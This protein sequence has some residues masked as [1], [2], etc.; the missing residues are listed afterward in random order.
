MEPQ[1]L[2]HLFALP[3]QSAV[4][5]SVLGAAEAL[6]F[7]QKTGLEDGKLRMLRFVSERVVEERR[8]DPETGNVTTVHVNRPVEISVPLIS[9]LP[10]VGAR[11]QDIE[12]D[13]ALDVVGVAKAPLP[14]GRVVAGPRPV[15]VAETRAV[16]VPSRPDTPAGMRVRMR[17][18]AEP[19]E[20]A[21]RIGELLHEQIGGRPVAPGPDEEAH[22]GQ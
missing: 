18:V 17:L 11:I 15:S 12:V 19:P 8:R 9:L 2:S 22:H 13:F 1:P 14:F 6:S 10:P 7:F 3:I 16:L 20:G 21:A 5:A 4:R